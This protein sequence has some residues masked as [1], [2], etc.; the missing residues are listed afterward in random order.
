MDGVLEARLGTFESL[1][2]KLSNPWMDP[3]E[4][5]ALPLTS[6]LPLSD[7]KMLDHRKQNTHSNE[8]NPEMY[9]LLSQK[10]TRHLTSGMAGSRGSILASP[11]PHPPSRFHFQADCPHRY[12]LTFYQLSSK[13]AP[14]QGP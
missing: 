12:R 7:I 3:C 14:S 1:G 13:R 9:W 2:N 10:I 6:Y 8:P 5:N 11:I 4:L